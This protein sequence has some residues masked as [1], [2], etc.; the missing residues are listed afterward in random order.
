MEEIIKNQFETMSAFVSEYE[1]RLR[2][3]FDLEEQI[4]ILKGDKFKHEVKAKEKVYYEVDEESGKKKYTNEE[5]RSIAAQ[6]LLERNEEY[7][8]IR[9]AVEKIESEIGKNKL[10]VD[11]LL[12]RISVL[13]K[14][15]DLLVALASFKA[16]K[17]DLW[18]LKN[19]ND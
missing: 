11:V 19:E 10:E 13:S 9:I 7:Q 17:K 2:E 1:R 18:G 4:E 16:Q 12:K 6:N 3:K 5:M 15:V 8:K 14:Q